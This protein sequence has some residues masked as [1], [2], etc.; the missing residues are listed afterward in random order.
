MV[1]WLK[2]DIFSVFTVIDVS[3]LKFESIQLRYLT[4]TKELFGDLA[5][6]TSQGSNKEP[7]ILKQV[8]SCILWA[9]PSCM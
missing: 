9:C 5:W 3:L 2:P 8:Q 7:P 6:M 1:Q 4:T